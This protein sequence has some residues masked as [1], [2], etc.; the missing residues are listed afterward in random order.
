[1]RI[2]KPLS[3][4]GGFHADR[5]DPSLPEL[6]FL[7]EQWAPEDYQIGRHSHPVWEFYLQLHG[8]SVWRDGQGGVYRCAAG[9]FFSP[10]PGL[11]HWLDQTSTGKHHFMFAAI[12]VDRIVAKLAA[13]L[14]RQWQPR[15]VLHLR[16]GGACEAAFRR[17]IR[18]TTADRPFRSESLR[19]ALETLVLD[20]SRMVAEAAGAPGRSLLPLHPAVETARLAMDS[21]PSEPWRLE[22]LAAMAGVSPNHLATLF[23]R[24]VGLAPHAYLIRVRV[25]KAKELLR[26]T[27]LTVT[28]IAHDL[29]FHSSQHF[30][31]TFRRIVG[32]TPSAFRGEP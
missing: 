32:Q 31:R 8:W 7:G 11:E 13:D 28:R 6:H 26:D 4:V 5:P 19:R 27:D 9:A 17:L 24:E 12:D 25:A 22:A 15:R 16:N 10:P 2:T 30:A 14:Q 1:M 23:A 18:E 21:H 29:G 20:V 3:I